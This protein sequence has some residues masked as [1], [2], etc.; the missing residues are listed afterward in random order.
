MRF[1][2]QPK[3]F[4]GPPGRGG[5]LDGAEF[6]RGRRSC[7]MHV[8]TR[9]RGDDRDGRDSA[10]DRRPGPSCRS[11]GSRYLR[12]RMPRLQLALQPQQIGAD[13]RGALAPD[14]AILLEEV[15][16]HPVELGRDAGVELQRRDR[17]AVEDRFEDDRRC[18]SGERQGASRHLIEHDAERKQ[19]GA[20][21]QLFA[22]RLLGRH[23]RDGSHGRARTGEKFF[24][25]W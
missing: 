16:D 20:R 10:D 25:P 18:R 22:A 13:V 21:V 6:D 7:A 8:R 24:V 2:Q 5:L 11:R 23:I 3:H 12:G 9:C 14:I 1:L 4:V 17:R 15:M 19:I